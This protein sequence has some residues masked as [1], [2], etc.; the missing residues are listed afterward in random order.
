MEYSIYW[1]GLEAYGDFGLFADD[2]E[3][4]RANY[5]L[6]GHFAQVV[7]SGSR[8]L[9]VGFAQTGQDEQTFIVLK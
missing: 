5:S 9:G 6:W 8:E 3:E 4:D 1:K 7:W 2:K